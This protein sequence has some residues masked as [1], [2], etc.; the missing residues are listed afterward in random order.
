MNRSG[1]EWYGTR[2]N[3]GD[4]MPLKDAKES[5]ENHKHLNQ[6][7]GCQSQN[8]GDA[9]HTGYYGTI[10]TTKKMPEKEQRGNH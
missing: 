1:T 3:K 4:A 9:M 10:G 2:R 8:K 5:E 6:E 7:R